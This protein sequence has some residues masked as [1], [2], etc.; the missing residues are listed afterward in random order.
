M[1]YRYEYYE[2]LLTEFKFA[3]LLMLTVFLLVQAFAYA[4]LTLKTKNIRCE[5]PS[6]R[7]YLSFVLRDR[8]FWGILFIAFIWIVWVLGYVKLK[9]PF[10][11]KFYGEL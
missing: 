6:F 4:R 9:L 2:R 3:F 8:F 1:S 11:L 7:D 10:G 5:P